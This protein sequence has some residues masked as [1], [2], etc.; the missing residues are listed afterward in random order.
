MRTWPVVVPA[1]GRERVGR[2]EVAHRVLVVDDTA[3]IRML[4]RVNLELEGFDVD[5]ATDGAA[6]LALL[7]E[8]LATGGP[9]PAVVTLDAVMEPLD[10]WA[11]VAAIRR[12]P[13]LEHLRVVMVTASVQ[14]HHRRQAERGGVDAFVDKPFEPLALVDLVRG[15]ATAADGD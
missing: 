4:I 1:P 2:A 6:A 12:E 7:R 5:E 9:L 13:G 3:Q 10:G 8:R 15:L 11:T 14:A